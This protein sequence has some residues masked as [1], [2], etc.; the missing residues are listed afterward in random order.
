[1]AVEQKCEDGTEEDQVTATCMS[2]LGMDDHSAMSLTAGL[3]TPSCAG[4]WQYMADRSDWSNASSDVPV[5]VHCRCASRKISLDPKSSLDIACNPSMLIKRQATHVVVG[6]TYGL[7]AF[8]LFPHKQPKTLDEDATRKLVKFVNFF[9]EGLLDGR[10]RLE[11]DRDEEDDVEDQIL[12]DMHCTLYS[13]L[14]TGQKWTSKPVSE[15]YDACR[16]VLYHQT[17]KAVPLKVWLY[18][19][20]KLFLAETGVNKMPGIQRDISRPLVIRCQKMWHRLKQVRLQTDKLMDEMDTSQVPPTYRQRIRDFDGLLKRFVMTLSKSLLD[21]T[22]SVRRSAGLNEESME[23]MVKA[24]ESKSPFVPNEL[25]RWIN[26]Q[27]QQVNTLNMLSKLPGFSLVLG[28]AQLREEILNG[29]DGFAVVLH[30]PSLAE[31]SDGLVPEMSRFVDIFAT[32]LP[33]SWT[34]RPGMGRTPAARR[35]FYTAGQDFSDWITNHNADASPVRY[36]VCYEER[37]T[38]QNLPAL[39]LYNY[40]CPEDSSIFNIPKSPGQVVVEKNRLGVITLSWPA[41]HSTTSF[42]LQYKRADLPG[43][44]WD[45]MRHPTNTITI[46][47]LQSD[48]SYVFRVAAVTLGGKSPFGPVSEEVSIDPVCPPPSGLKCLNG[49]DESITIAWNHQKFPAEEEQTAILKCFAVECW[50]DGSQESTL[51]QRSTVHKVITLEPLVPDTVYCVQIR[52]VSSDDKG[53]K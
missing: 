8:C 46:N 26:H 32:S 11:L 35:R 44:R 53:S 5:A 4:A 1:M 30:L 14:K 20:R 10:E 42:L 6:I 19:I 12:L 16:E 27:R 40:G 18:P 25:A 31:H 9:A 7:E 23:E 17:N 43:D 29:S 39:K 41:I 33:A 48:E 22:L 50:T 34:K 36:I 37:P 38:G 28:S 3:I 15:Q 21:W 49:T 51:I 2:D 13:D 47:H 52:A 24:I 45:A